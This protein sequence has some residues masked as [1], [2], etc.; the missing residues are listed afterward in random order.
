[1][2]I[3]TARAETW[4]AMGAGTATMTEAAETMTEVVT[5]TLSGEHISRISYFAFFSLS[6]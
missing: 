6:V 3:G 4:T 2:A 5:I 1:M